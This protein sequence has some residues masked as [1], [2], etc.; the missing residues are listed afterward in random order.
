MLPP[1]PNGAIIHI[2]SSIRMIMCDGWM[3]R[4]HAGQWRRMSLFV[5]DRGVVDVEVVA[6]AA[7]DAALVSLGLVTTRRMKERR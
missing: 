6:V 2:Q 3:W 5:A 4:E 7:F 1:I